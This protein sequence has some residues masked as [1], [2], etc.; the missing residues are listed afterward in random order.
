MTPP[1][2]ARPPSDAT[3]TTTTTNGFTPT[4]HS[5]QGLLDSSLV[6]AEDWEALPDRTREE[7]LHCPDL[8]AAL[9]LLVKHNLLTE[10]QAARVEAGK[11]HGL[12]L[13]NYRVLE[14]IGAGGMGVVF[15]AEHLRMRRIVALKVLPLHP[16]LDTRLLRRFIGEMRALAQLQHP[17][18]VSALDDGEAAGSGAGD[19]PLHYFV[20]EYVPGQDLEALVL[21]QGPLSSPA[22][23]GLAYQVASALAA[24]HER[25]LVHRDIKPSNIRVTPD[26]QAKLLDFG[27]VRHGWHRVTEPGA[28][29]GTL[30]Y[31]APEQAQ[32]ASAVDIRADVYGLGGT[33]YWCLTGR[34]PFS[35]EGGPAASLL[36]RLSQ[37]PPRARDANPSVSVELD[38]VVARMMALDPADRYPTPQAVMNAL[39]PFLKT[40]SQVRVRPARSQG[41]GRRTGCR[42]RAPAACA[43]SWWS[44]T[45]PRAASS[46]PP[47]WKR[48]ASPAMWWRMRSRRWGRYGRRLTTW[49]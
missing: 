49:C 29:L 18:I 41:R 3:R 32:D 10:Y 11:S 39:L 16:D 36:R 26:G 17:H 28:V 9:S 14:R 35:C 45:V 46:A 1:L 48:R 37:Q 44:M 6:V 21:E 4:R 31:L 15:K 38:A 34:P 23:C 42:R 5:L 33:L 47:C 25:D 40:D 19:P 13:G 8:G 30:D 24:A 2:S 22:A 7:L 27:L 43:E 20:M 12:V